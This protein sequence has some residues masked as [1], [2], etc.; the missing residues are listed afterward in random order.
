MNQ[1]NA[2]VGLFELAI[3]VIAAADAIAKLIEHRVKPLH[4]AG[5]APM[6][7]DRKTPYARWACDLNIVIID[8]DRALAA[9]N[10]VDD[11]AHSGRPGEVGVGVSR[12]KGQHAAKIVFSIPLL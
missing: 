12:R 11:F 1:L 3:H 5:I 6:R 2:M 4:M 8:R 10:R 9:L 7:S